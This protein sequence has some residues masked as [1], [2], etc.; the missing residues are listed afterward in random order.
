MKIICIGRNYREHA[1]ELNSPVPLEPVFFMK[2]DTS[3]LRRNRPFHYPDFSRE[4]HYEV[5]LVARICKA[6]KNIPKNVASSYYDAI[7][8]G[9]DFTARDLQD[10]C[11]KQGL[12]WLISKGFDHSAPISRFIPKP[13]FKDTHQIRFHLDL[14]GKTVQEGSSAD[15]IFDF[16]D[17]ISYISRFITLRTGDMIFTGTP[18]G[19]GPVRLGDRLEGYLEGE[20]ML[21]C[22]IR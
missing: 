5:E 20:R 1:R 19:V 2:P 22:T 3:L 8:I 9:F 11:K 18:A 16:E 10:R 12:P 17:L 7:G 6:G 14:N 21:S 13:A 4:I 15:M